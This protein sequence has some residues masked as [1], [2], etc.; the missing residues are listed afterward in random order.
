AVERGDGERVG[1][2]M[3]E[4]AEE[5][6]VE[7]RPHDV[8][9][10]ALEPQERAVVVAGLVTDREITVLH[11]PEDLHLEQ[12]EHGIG[13]P[14]ATGEPIERVD[15]HPLLSF[16]TMLAHISPTFLKRWI[17]PAVNR[18]LKCFSIAT[19]SCMC[20]NES[21]PGTSSAVV[22]GPIVMFRSPSSSAK[23]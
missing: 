19:T 3:Q 10:K 14:R 22:W 12:Q 5:R 17:S 23:M 7:R 21:H 18:I 1:R 11:A 15:L 2:E 4:G 8:D 16:A 9:R 6:G 13:D 20:V